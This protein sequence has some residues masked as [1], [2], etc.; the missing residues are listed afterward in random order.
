[1]DFFCFENTG[2]AMVK[3]NKG[4]YSESRISPLSSSSSFCKSNQKSPAAAFLYPILH[5]YSYKSILGSS[6]TFQSRLF[7]ATS[8]L[9]FF[10]NHS[11]K[12]T[13]AP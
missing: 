12:A 1:M 9:I 4:L 11:Q 10:T 3:N 2:E 7:D 6:P 8:S 5:V 13:T